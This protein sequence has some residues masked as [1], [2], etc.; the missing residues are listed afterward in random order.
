MASRKQWLTGA[1]AAT[2]LLGGLAYM[3]RIDIALGLVSFSMDRR[4]AAGPSREISWQ[5][6][7]DLQGRAPD[8]RPPNIVLILA[9]DL[10]WN[11][12]TFN[13]GG[14]A[15]GTVPTP[16]IDSIAQQGVTFMN[17]YAANDT[18]APSRAAL[19]SGKNAFEAGVTHPILER[20]RMAPGLTTV[21]DVLRK[22][23]YTTGTTL[24]VN[25]GMAM[26]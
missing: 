4:I 20:E 21:A 6:G 24:H 14:V 11:D 16:H 26:I 10:G 22:A 25:G 2:V 9:D 5:S 12:L 13:G 23:G 7:E 19:M 1:L 18:C 3:K 17:G 15:N 8:E